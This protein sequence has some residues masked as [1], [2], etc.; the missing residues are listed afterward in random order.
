MEHI[1]RCLV[2]LNQLIVEE[3]HE[4]ALRNLLYSTEILRKRRSEEGEELQD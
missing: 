2:E 3:W 1:N 4:K